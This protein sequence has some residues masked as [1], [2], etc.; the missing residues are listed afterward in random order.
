MDP[1]GYAS[2][3]FDMDGVLLR[4]N[5]LKEQA[6]Y[7]VALQYGET[8]AETM[9]ALHRA[10]G[11]ISRRE[12][13]ERFFSHV[14]NRE[15]AENEISDC[16]ERTTAILGRLMQNVDLMPGVE[17]YLSAWID[18]GSAQAFVVSGVTAGEVRA[19]LTQKGIAYRFS[20]IFGGRDKVGVMTML[21]RSGVIT[22]PAIY[23]GDTED[24][25]RSAREAGLDFCLVFGDSTWED[26]TTKMRGH[27]GAVADFRALL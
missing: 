15:G 10:A 16:V 4:S 19:I 21:V 5:R 22:Q 17:D 1:A 3:V 2:H 13:W 18:S 23:F 14:L 12:R 9:V 8:A 25:W 26:W 20:G 6:F 27:V 7:E 11:S 24:D